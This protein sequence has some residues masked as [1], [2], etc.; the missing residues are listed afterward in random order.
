[1]KL[2]PSTFKLRPSFSASVLFL[3]IHT[4]AIFCVYFVSILWWLKLVLVGCILTNF[5][6]IL[7]DNTLQHKKSIKEFW[8][9]DDGEWQLQKTSGELI[10]AR[11]KYP[12]FVSNYLIIVNFLVSD[13]T[14]ITFPIFRDGWTEDDWRKLKTALRRIGS[15]EF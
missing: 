12:I 8:L 3:F 1:M 10:L 13:S 14:K 6:V 9:K 5:I 15:R 4:G 11:I 7:R 2:L